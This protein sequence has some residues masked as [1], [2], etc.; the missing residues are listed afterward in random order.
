MCRRVCV[1]AVLA[2]V[3][4]AGC[5]EPGARWHFDKLSSRALVRAWV[6]KD[7]ESARP[8][9]VA[10]DFGAWSLCRA[11]DLT[12]NKEVPAQITGDTLVVAPPAP[13]QNGEERRYLVYFGGG[14]SAPGKSDIHIAESGRVD[15]P[16]YTA[17]LALDRGGVLSSL[18]LKNGAEILGGD[19]ISWWIGRD[20][21]IAQAK[22]KPKMV[23]AAQGPVFA[24]ARF[25]YPGILAKT[26]FMT[27]EYRF[28]RRF[29]EVRHHYAC[30]E[31]VKLLW[32]KLPITLRATGNEPGLHSCSSYTN[33]KCLTEGKQGKWV[34]DSVWHDVS[35]LGSRP[36]GIGVIAEKNRGNLYFMDSVKPREHEWIYAEPFGWNKPVNI[37][38]DIDLCLAY[39]PHRAGRDGWRTTA[40]FLPGRLTAEISA[41][42]RKG[43]PPIDTDKDGLSDTRELA[44]GTNLHHVDTDY[45]G[46]PDARDPKP[47]QADVTEPPPTPSLAS[48]PTDRKQS[49]AKVERVGGVPTIVINGEAFGPMTFTSCAMSNQQMARV[50]DRGFQLNFLMV[51]GVGWPGRQEDIFEKL[52][53][54]IENFLAAAPK[55]Y[56]VLRC[57][58]CAP[59]GFVKDH[60]EE[61]ITFNDGSI[62]HFT[63]W[64]WVK[65]YPPEERGY[66]SFASKVW[67]EGTVQALRRYV[68]HIRRSRYA[69]RVVGYFICGGGTE[70]WYYWGDYDHNKYCVD[71][72][73]PMLHAFRRLLQRKYDGDVRKLRAAWAD[74]TADFAT[75]RPP[76]MGARRNTD[77]GY[78]WDP[79]KSK[80]VQDYYECHNRV[81][82]ESVLLFSRAVKAASGG[83]ALVGMFH[84]YLLN[85]WLL[86]GGQATL[87]DVLRS[88]DNDFWSG[89]PQY[90]RRGHG[91]HGCIR[92]L[93]ASLKKH[94]KLWI[95][96]SDIRTSFVKPDPNNPAL[97]GRPPDL[98][99]SIACL[100]REFGHVLCEGANGWWFP[101]GRNWYD[102]PAILDLFEQMQLVGRSAR[103][104]DRRADTDI[105]VVVDLDSLFVTPP[106]PV[107]N[108]LLGAF[109]VQELCRIGAP[110]DF[111]E[112]DDILEP[113]AKRYKM[114]IF[115]N[116]FSLTA[117]ERERIK[118]RLARNGAT[119]VWMW[120]PG[121]FHPGKQPQMSLAHCENLTGI[122]LDCELGADLSLRMKLTPEGAAYAAGFPPG[123]V[124]GDFERPKWVQGKAPGSFVRTSPGPRKWR[125]RFFAHA[126]GGEIV[127]RFVEGGKPSCVLRRMTD[128]TDIWIGSVMAPADLL[129]AFAKRAGCRLYCDGDEIIYASKS[130]LCI[131]TAA[132]GQRTF[133]LRRPSDVVEVFTGKVMVRNGTRF[134][135]NI[136]ACRTR[137]YFLGSADAWQREMGRSKD[138]LKTLQDDLSRLRKAGENP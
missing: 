50:V 17:Q 68:T 40:A 70:E 25:T 45:D 31:P 129:R 41:F 67:R 100:K 14:P 113:D 122:P 83:Q 61:C 117:T 138:W 125:Q 96:E 28:F 88:P 98:P 5:E 123:R 111:Y 47:L 32:F 58:V 23:V 43:G 39:V 80:R 62:R 94:G 8:I 89:P 116:A 92:F 77:F 128:H 127:S 130:F 132:S 126:K 137:L 49:V 33:A 26:N 79:A 1:A 87:K 51:G 78:F 57:Y 9:S 13:L 21:Q 42:Q 136:P 114:Y 15:T 37:T 30:K 124:F 36:F 120:A 48:V 99:E 134:T 52:D 27:T 64:Y 69:D 76:L 81:M 12:A 101:M 46:L 103:A 135:D 133:H 35:Y 112:M 93:N 54:R 90:D 118:E 102:H 86:E 65:R 119:L 106:W 63:K 91:E 55:A 109:R 97:Y 84:G 104:F 29:I 66:P 20:P 19:G 24:S 44:L 6:S 59:P 115:L 108:S 95:D 71:F 73:K 34:P 105:A 110:C 131:H 72:S 16:A 85:H 7:A 38:E 18:K 22:L 75:A 3:L 4:A 121:L 107:S 2:F 11:W 82:E 74:D 53:R 10:G 60:P 56:L